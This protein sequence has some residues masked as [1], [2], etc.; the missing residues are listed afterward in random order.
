VP[1]A[2][3]QQPA[4]DSVNASES[5]DSPIVV[6]G[7]RSLT[8]D[9]IPEGIAHA[10][11]SITV[12]SHELLEQQATS[13]VQDALKNVPG[14]TFNAGEGGARGD[15]VNLRGFPAFNDFFLDG[16]RDAAVYARDSFNLESIEVLKGP[17]AVLF[18]RGSTGGVIN[19]VSK[20]PTLTPL[21]AAT[22][23]GGTND[24]VRA[25]ADIDQPIG[26]NAAIRINAMGEHSKVA[27]RDLVR[28]RRWG[29]AP[30]ISV[31]IGGP[32]MLTVEYLHQEENDIPDVGIPFVGNRPANVS[33]N[34]DY[35]LSTDR[36]LSNV[37]I[38]TGHY[39]HEFSSAIS[40]SNTLRYADYYYFDRFNG[41]NFGY[42]DSPGAPAST[43]PLDQI[44]VGRDTPASSG[45]RT[46]LTDQTDLVANF[47]TGPVSHTVIAGVEFGREH[48]N[49]IRYLNP[50]GAAGE[51]PA[52]PLL[53]PDPYEVSPV[54][55][56]RTRAVTTAYSE[57]AYII[58]TVHL[59]PL[60]DVTGGVRFDRFAAHYR[61]QALVA[62][63]SAAS[64]VP[65]DHV[66]NVWSPRASIVFNPTA[67]ARLYLSY[68][69]SFDPSAEALSL[70]AKTA[71]LGPV[72]AKS[73]ELGGKADWHDGKIATTA[74]IFRTEI[75]NAQVTDP[76]HPTALVLAGDERVDGV[77]LGVTGHLTA[78]WEITAGYTY[79][80][81]KT[82]SSS[83]AATVGK[84]L[85]NT[86]RNSVNLWTEYEF[87]E[88]FE[89][90][91]GG[92]Y[93]GK[94]FSDFAEQAVLPSY[95]IVDAMGAWSPNNHLTLR[96]NVNNLFN[97]LAW[98]NSYYASGEENHV[99]P[100]PGRT[101]L[102]TA[103][104]KY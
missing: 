55:P 53:A 42:N 60:F 85:A 16:I 31:G 43:T 90:G 77:E 41:P 2:I 45:H 14:I 57:A 52:T 22:L 35:G 36:F 82:L 89:L 21:Y 94:R 71:D 91:A 32:D 66:D 75:D 12:V 44:M 78:K 102:F 88:H 40:I 99:I 25:T 49:T 100:A 83:N 1:I 4:G 51:T 38:A 24:E 19:Q 54:E 79:L 26:S 73:F 104:I 96:V 58:D 30:S 15:T 97:K 93:L 61:P 3:A 46:N 17:S 69:T 23:V 28:S 70:S 87:S 34:L 10:P 76:D 18:G 5:S 33:R 67:H 9:K 48:D 81:G 13:R 64:L 103:A 59:G 72:K 11:Q 101:A 63:V 65:L 56:G 62:G 80:D 50:F 37:D 74:A 86:A 92:N 8:L 39:R 84:R 29:V 68:G 6:T 95:V 7:V 47:A 27:D 98:Q 20:A